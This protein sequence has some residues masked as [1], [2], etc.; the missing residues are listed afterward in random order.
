MPSEKPQLI[1]S[2]SD[3]SI[4]SVLGRTFAN[5][6]LNPVVCLVLPFVAMFGPA[7]IVGIMLVGIGSGNNAG[8]ASS[9]GLSIATLIGKIF[10]LITQGAITCAVYCNL[11]GE[12]CSMPQLLGVDLREWCLCF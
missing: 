10:M 5:I 8:T 4:A 9:I 6:A 2:S 3:F 7:F 12:T 1:T 11:R